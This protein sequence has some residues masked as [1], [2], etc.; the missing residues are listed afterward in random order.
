MSSAIHLPGWSTGL[1]SFGHRLGKIPK[2][3]PR[4]YPGE[5]PLL[6]GEGTCVSLFESRTKEF[7]VWLGHDLNPGHLRLP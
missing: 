6:W 2:E 5:V 3:K 4:P 1:A 7:Q